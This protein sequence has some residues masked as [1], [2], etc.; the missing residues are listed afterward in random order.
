MKRFVI[1][2]LMLISILL[3]TLNL[4]SN[5]EEVKEEKVV[6]KNISL[7]STIQAY[8]YEGEKTDKTYE[9]LLSNKI[10]NKITCK[11]G[12]IA[13]FNYEDNSVS[14]SN[15]KLPDYC[16]ID[17]KEGYMVTLNAGSTGTVSPESQTTGYNGS[18]SFTVTPSDG[19]KAKLSTNTCGGTL[20][21]N[22]YTINNVKENK[23]CS[24]EFKKNGTVLSTLIK[25]YSSNNTNGV[26]NE[27]GYRYEGSD[28]SNYIYMTNKSTNEKELW[29]I[30][31]VF[32]D[33]A[34]GEEVIRVRRHYEQ[35]SYPEMAYDTSGSIV[36]KYN[37]IEE[38]K[39]DL[40]AFNYI[41]NKNYIAK[42]DPPL[43]PSCKNH[44]P[45]STMY[46]ELKD[47]YSTT[48]YKY[49]VD[50][51]MYLGG[52]N[53]YD[54]PYIP[55][56]LYDMER[57]LNGKGTAGKTSSASYS[58]VTMFIGSVGIMYP[59]DYAYAVLASDCARTT[60]NFGYY[61][62]STCH[63]NN[64]LYQGSN[65]WQWL[66]SPCPYFVYSTFA[67]FGNGSFY[68]SGAGG[69]ATQVSGMAAYSPVMAL[70]SDVIVDG[71]GNIDNP[72]IIV[73]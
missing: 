67:L 43:C 28:P 51:K 15:I 18:V 60:T 54:V 30:I 63:N 56:E 17:F 70:S 8:T 50:F 52:N 24:I 39:K 57:M 42:P 6:E 48:N 22:T 49:T 73:N 38:T 7:P 11:N 35:N 36:Y 27:N 68:A 59:S 47:T 14:L 64:W 29:R 16:T 1:I 13:K 40:L 12:T 61:S 62:T 53:I 66:I 71:S 4:G 10:V 20:S 72:Y 46:T 45:I 26:Y 5:E 31:G 69:G 19:Y 33:G 3:L 32:N 37:S 25:S 34:N 9:W 21:G 44:W 41:F 58:S 23:S 55:S 65:Q 2:V